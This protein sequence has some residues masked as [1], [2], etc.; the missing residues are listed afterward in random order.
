M[1][2]APKYKT[3]FRTRL[4]YDEMKKFEH[5]DL[6][7]FADVSRQMSIVIFLYKGQEDSTLV[8]LPGARCFHLPCPVRG[9][10]GMLYVYTYA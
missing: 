8:L 6:K 2:G 1:L 4:D 10:A 7:P 3:A 9:K 5:H